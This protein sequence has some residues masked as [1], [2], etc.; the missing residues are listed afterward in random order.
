MLIEIAAIAPTCENS[1][2]SAAIVAESSGASCSPA[3]RPAGLIAPTPSP[4]TNVP[5]AS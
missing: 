4:T 1:V 5:S 3:L 2:R